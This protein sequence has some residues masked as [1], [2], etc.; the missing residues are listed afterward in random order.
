MEDE[1]RRGA[2]PLVVHARHSTK[3]PQARA[4]IRRPQSPTRCG[5][6]Y[7]L[8]SLRLAYPISVMP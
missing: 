2:G 8:N 6:E 5:L 7:T 1:L 3:G 4:L